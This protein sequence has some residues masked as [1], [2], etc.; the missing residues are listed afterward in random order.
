MGWPRGDGDVEGGPEG[1]CGKQCDDRAHRLDPEA[2]G[3][4]AAHE[5]GK[6]G[7]HSAGWAGDA[8]AGF[9]LALLE[10][11]LARGAEAGGARVQFGGDEEDAE[12]GEGDGEGDEAGLPGEAVGVVGSD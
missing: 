12:A 9:E 5:M 6:T 10:A 11:E 8:G 1:H 3:N 2:G 4:L 7:G